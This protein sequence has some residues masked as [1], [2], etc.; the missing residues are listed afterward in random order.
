MGLDIRWPIGLMF[1]V[2]GLL[3]VIAGFT[4]PPEQLQRS[5]GININLMWGVGLLVFGG[6]MTFFAWRGSQKNGQNP[7]GK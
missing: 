7:P 3:M 2:V 1:L 5:L 4:V 6:L